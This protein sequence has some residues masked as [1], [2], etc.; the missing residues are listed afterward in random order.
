MRKERWFWGLA[1]LLAAVLLIGSQL[2]WFNYPFSSGTLI[3]TFLIVVILIKNLIDLS[4]TGIIFSL[5]FLF[6]LYQKLLG[7]S[8][9]GWTIFL[10]AL[11]LNIG[12]SLIFGPIIHRHHFISLQTLFASNRSRIKHIKKDWPISNDEVIRLSGGRLTSSTKYLQARN[13]K[14]VDV[15][16]LMSD[17]SIYFDQVVAKDTQV[18]VKLDCTASNLELYIPQGWQVIDQ[19]RPLMSNVEIEPAVDATV[20]TNTILLTGQLKASNLEAYYLD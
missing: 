14:E 19:L 17:M 5:A 20:L 10:A 3:A 9:S 16:M 15:V 12:L 6:F 11:L 13:L 7:I 1:C 18:E 2:Q 8:L 4:L